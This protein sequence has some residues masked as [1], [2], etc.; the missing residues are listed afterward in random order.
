M[1]NLEFGKDH[2]TTKHKEYNICRYLESHV[3]KPKSIRCVHDYE[4]SNIVTQF[5]TKSAT[6]FTEGISSTDGTN[7]KTKKRETGTQTKEITKSSQE[8]TKEY[9]TR[10][11][12]TINEDLLDKLKAITYRDRLLIKDLV[13]TPLQEAVTKYDKKSGDNKPITKK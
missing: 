2:V 5:N 11:T 9:E 1:T 4:H 13:I 7:R 10:V 3:D 6:N 8:G 12:F